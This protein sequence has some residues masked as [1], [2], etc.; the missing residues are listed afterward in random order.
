MPLGSAQASAGY[1]TVQ[2]LNVVLPQEKALAEESQEV[3]KDFAK[4][5]EGGGSDQKY[6]YDA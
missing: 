6:W 5:K 1:E 4:L 2:E 3:H